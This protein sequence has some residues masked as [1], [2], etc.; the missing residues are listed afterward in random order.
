LFQTQPSCSCCLCF[1]LNPAFLAVFVSNSTQ[2]FLLSLFQTQP[3]FSCCICFKLNPAVLAV[4][5]SN[6]TPLFLLSLFQ[7]QYSCS[8]SLCFKLN[9]A[10]LAVFV[11]NSTQLFL[12]SLFQTQ[13]IIC[14]LILLQT[15]YFCSKPDCCDVIPSVI[16]WHISRVDLQF[17]K[18]CKLPGYLQSL[19][20][21]IHRRKCVDE[22]VHQRLFAAIYVSC[23]LAQVLRRRPPPPP[24]AKK[25]TFVCY[26]GNPCQKIFLRVIFNKCRQM[27]WCLYS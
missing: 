8:C 9:P 25:Y 20:N 11:S 26:D 7:T 22:N 2:L 16:Y 19:T 17:P 5:V 1:K 21:P 14:C 10:V 4:F 24:S 15:K 3:S 6:S 12:L 27:L 13:V 23:R 18:Y